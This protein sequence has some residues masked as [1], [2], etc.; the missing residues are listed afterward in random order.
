MVRDEFPRD[1]T[2]GRQTAMVFQKIA[3]FLFVPRVVI[4]STEPLPAAALIESDVVQKEIQIDVEDS[5]AAPS[6][7][8]E[9]S[10]EDPIVPIRYP[11]SSG[12]FTGGLFHSVAVLARLA[13][14]FQSMSASV[15]HTGAC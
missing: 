9:I 14:N 7:F 11:R 5:H 4:L 13:F 8:R 12:G 15:R 6:R 2:A 3:H 1:R 10:T